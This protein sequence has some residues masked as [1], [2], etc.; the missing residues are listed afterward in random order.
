VEPHFDRQP[1]LFLIG[2]FFSGHSQ[3]APEKNPQVFKNQCKT[4]SS[5]PLSHRQLFLGVTL[6]LRQRK[7]CKFLKIRANKGILTLTSNPP[8]FHKKLYFSDY[9][10]PQLT[11]YEVYDQLVF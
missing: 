1:P 6:W 7:I 11:I 8:L 9:T 4:L 5:N 10:G 2:N 3:V